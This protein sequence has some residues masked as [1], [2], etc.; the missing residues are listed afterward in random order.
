MPSSIAVL[1]SKLAWYLT[2]TKGRGVEGANIKKAMKLQPR[3]AG[4]LFG[5][6]PQVLH[7]RYVHGFLYKDGCPIHD[8][9]KGFLEWMPSVGTISILERLAARH[10]KFYKRLLATLDIGVQEYISSCAD[11]A[12]AKKTIK[13]TLCLHNVSDLAGPSSQ[14]QN[15]RQLEAERDWL[16]EVLQREPRASPPQTKT[17]TLTRV[18]P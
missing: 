3:A 17:K 6:S 18:L 7:F 1:A 4:S 15:H 13:Q 14:K 8:S 12:K 16:N 11:A 10:H 9:L 2:S 5:C